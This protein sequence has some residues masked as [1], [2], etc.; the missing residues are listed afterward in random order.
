MVLTDAVSR[1]LFDEYAGHRRTDRGAEETGWVLLGL[2]HADEA[3]V[4]ATLPA[5]A[6]RDAGEA[7]VWIT[8]ASHVLASR[9]VRQTDR[10]LV[11][12]GVVHTHPGSLRHPSRGDL[13]GDRDWVPNLRGGEGVFA[14]GTV[15]GKPAGAGVAVGGHPTPNVQ[16]LAG[17]RFDW[18]TLAAGDTAY[19]PVPVELTIG[20]DL[21][22]PLRPVWDVI[23]AHADRLDRLARRFAAVRFE[24]ADAGDGPALLVTVGL[25]GP[26][27]SVQV[28]LQGKAVRFFYDAGGELTQLDLPAGTAPDHGVYLLLAELAARE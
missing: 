17:L 25:G 21:G 18:Y 24:V 15:A 1:T 19:R 14:I 23:E 9:V 16:T 11:I 13:T 28:L 7:H 3:L 5:A 26:A 12:L 27:E 10:R 2:R 22:G 20:P 6:D 4:L 8:G